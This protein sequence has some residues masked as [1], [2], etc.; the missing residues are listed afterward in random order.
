VV[1]QVALACVLLVSS[2]L[3][4]R[5]LLHLSR[6]PL[7]FRA[8]NVLV[9]RVALGDPYAERSRRIDYFREL[10]D[11]LRAVPSVT[12]VG[13]STVM[14][15]NPF[16]ID[17]DVPYHLPGSPEPERAT[18]PKARFRSATPGYFRTLGTPLLFGRDFTWEDREDTPRVV[19]VNRALARRLGR[20][21]G[22]VGTSLRFFWADWQTYEIVGV[23]ED[24][25]SYR[26]NHDPLPELFVP[27]S[28]IPYL[29]MNVAVASSGPAESLT[30]AVRSV[31]LDLDPDE[32]AVGTTTLSTL[33]SAT[34]A[35]ENLAARLLS[36]LSTAA[37]LLA[38]VSVYAVLSFTTRRRTREIGIRMAL[39]ASPGGI[40]KWSLRQ[41]AVLT[42][43]GIAVGLLVSAAATGLLSELLFGVGT[44]DPFT[45]AAAPLLLFVLSMSASYLAVRPAVRIDPAAAFRSE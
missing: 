32:P 39:G 7:G 25:R 40:L 28:Q 26:A 19:I 33:V 22:A 45:F 42:F 2:G 15:M 4:G 5:T 9:A 24:T 8:E 3:L 27:Y 37:L 31:F 34:M 12:S 17:F 21:E 13:A 43:V 20:G 23:V 38:L 10:L 1:A 30:G 29:V 35:R 14:P 44:R 18:A 11:G 41:G 16:G 36:A 6:V